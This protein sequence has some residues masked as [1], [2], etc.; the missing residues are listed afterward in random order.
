MM[1]RT[2]QEGI[3]DNP[4]GVTSTTAD[5]GPKAKIEDTAQAHVTLHPAEI[6]VLIADGPCLAPESERNI[7][8]SVAGCGKELISAY[9]IRPANE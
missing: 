6:H 1:I 2:D 8:L 7:E 5:V 3:T 9:R 4:D